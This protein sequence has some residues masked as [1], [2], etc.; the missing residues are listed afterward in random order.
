LTLKALVEKGFD[1]GLLRERMA[2]SAN[3]MMD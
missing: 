1:D 3:R 2:H